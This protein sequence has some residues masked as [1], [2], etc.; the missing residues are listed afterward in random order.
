M[1]PITPTLTSMAP[2]AG[3]QSTMALHGV[4]P[5]F[6]L[7]LGACSSEQTFVVPEPRFARMM[8]Q[9]RYDP[10]EPSAFFADGRVMQRP[11]AGTVPTTRVLGDPGRTQGVVA[12]VYERT[13]PVPVDE[14]FVTHGQGRFSIF[15]APCHGMLGDANSVVGGNLP[16]VTPR[17]LLS[18]RIRDYPPGRIFRVASL[19]YGLMASYAVQL[20]PKDRWAVVSYVQALQ[21]ARGALLAELPPGLAA[22][23]RKALP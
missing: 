8:Q 1:S 13:F 18:A 11:P 16:L 3:G 10:Y 22:A 14:A 20:T 17:D 21:R 15:C 19:G 5:L 23:A 4:L 12:E 7:A 2:N 9:P 6:A